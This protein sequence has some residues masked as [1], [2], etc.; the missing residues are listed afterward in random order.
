MKVIIIDDSVIFRILLKTLVR[1]I[2]G[3]EV[4]ATASDG[5]AGLKAVEEHYPDVVLLDV[6]MPKLTGLE[7]LKEIK[8]KG[9]NSRVIMCSAFTVAGAEVTVKALEFGAHDFITKP[10]GKDKEESTALLKDQ[11]F[12][13]LRS[14]QKSVQEMDATNT[15]L[16]VRPEPKRI[17]KK[18]ADVL[19]I[20]IST[21]GPKALAVL[22][23]ALSANFKVPIVIVQHM[24]KL[25]I[26]SMASSLNEKCALTVKVAEDG[27]FIRAG[28]VYLAPG[29]KQMAVEDGKVK[30]TDDPPECFCKPAA[31]YLFRSL[32]ESYGEKAIGLVM[33]GMGSDGAQGLLKMKNAG[34]YT[35]GQDKKSCTIYGMPQEAA[36]A[37]AVDTVLSLDEIA[38]HLQNVI[39]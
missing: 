10:E 3:V 2:E 7:V 35:I 26:E 13:T 20:G 27:E 39:L 9:I 18:F 8:A 32:A 5:L 34:A 37:G 6:E 21:G 12:P 38:G 22:L 33:T 23:P 15:Q 19:G 29:E 36:K 4:C 1:S 14:I 28:F 11:L 17:V 30:I 24:P 16:Q 25:F 31:D